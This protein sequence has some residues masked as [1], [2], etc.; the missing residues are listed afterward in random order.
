MAVRSIRAAIR[1]LR[2]VDAMMHPVPPPV[3]PATVRYCEALA[4][5]GL[6]PAVCLAGVGA[7]YDQAL[8][9]VI[10]QVTDGRK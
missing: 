6:T 5:F 3:L 10:A 9:R 8:R 1:H 7:K 2:E 4:R